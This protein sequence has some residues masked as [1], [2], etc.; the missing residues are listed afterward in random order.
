MHDRDDPQY[1]GS[2]ARLC[3]S[4]HD[5]ERVV[6]QRKSLDA[7]TA[8]VSDMLGRISPSMEKETAIISDYL[9]SHYGVEVTVGP[10]LLDDVEA[11]AA[12]DES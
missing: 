3:T 11:L 10:L 6:N 12:A 5:L 9:T 4:C 2:L 1:I 8:T 7:W